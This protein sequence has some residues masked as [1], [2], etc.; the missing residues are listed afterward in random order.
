MSLQTATTAISLVVHAVL[1]GAIL[2]FS[3]QMELPRMPIPMQFSILH[4]TGA[5]VPGP[6]ANTKPNSTNVRQQPAAA[7]VESRSV[8]I[9]PKLLAAAKK[10]MAA[11]VRKSAL[12]RKTAPPQP[13]TQKLKSREN[14]TL[15]RSGEQAVPAS[16]GGA[17]EAAAAP[18][19]AKTRSAFG[20]GGGLFHASQ[21]DK[22]LAV[23]TQLAPAYPKR[24]R[25]QNIEGWIKVQF[26]V[27]ERGL[28]EMVKVLA[29][30]PQG[31][32]EKNVLQCVAAWRFKPGTIDGRVV[33]ALVE[34]TISFKLD[35]S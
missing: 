8:P 35:S 22:P 15:A 14:F 18:A 6:P 27:D 2:S 1:L 34:Q 33:K 13:K 25:R 11:P 19:T 24:A 30:E 12:V 9:Q 5:A 10:P 29:A 4:S 3:Y 23:L 32:F 17:N 16:I 28:V 26:V 20:G 7:A 31:I 21:L